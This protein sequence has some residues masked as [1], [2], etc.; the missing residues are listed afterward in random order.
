MSAIGALTAEAQ[1]PR[2]PVRPADYGQFERLEFRTPLSPDGRWLAVPVSRVDGTAELRTFSVDTDGPPIV[3]DEGRE[4][5]FSKD[6]AWLAYRIGQSEAER[7]DLLEDGEPVHDGVGLLHLAN[8]EVETTSGVSSFAFGGGGAYVALHRYALASDDDSVAERR[9]AD[10]VVRDL[11]AGGEFTIGNVAEYLW[12]P[13]GNLLAVAIETQD[14]VGNGVQLYDAASGRL[15][16]LGSA[17]QSG[18]TFLG[19]AWRDDSA[20]LAFLQSIHREGFDGPTHA[21]VAWRDL[22][23]APNRLL[24]DPAEAGEFVAGMRVSPHERPAWSDDGT[25]VFFAIQEWHAAPGDDVEDSEEGKDGAEP[26]EKIEPSAVEVW[27]S[28][29]EQVIPMQR[30]RRERNEQAGY[31]AAWNLAEGGFVRL[32]SDLSEVLAV[33]EGH[34]VATETDRDAYRFRNMFDR[35]WNDIWLIEIGSGARRRVI[36]DVGFFYGDSAGGRYLLYFKADHFWA[37]EIDTDTHRNLTAGL[38]GA[39]VNHDYD[40]PVRTQQPPWGV[41]G[42][43]ADDSAVLLYGE[44]DVWAVSP[45]GGGGAKLTNGDEDLVRHRVIDLES[46]ERG[47]DPKRI[48]LQLYG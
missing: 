35:D 14:G 31:R 21:I 27:H 47:V 32:G 9:G 10:L 40:T 2:P 12:Q 44:Y 3:A 34:R 28:F 39:F 38:P 18:T 19:L 37:Y 22:D 25:T 8:G 29:D 4:P 26:E 13:D 7:K 20:D 30:V 36:Q 17:A 15:R 43:L 45:G 23:A 41:G 5:E 6:S 16:V 48:W 24:Y 1:A 46:E 33:V 11:A 42:W